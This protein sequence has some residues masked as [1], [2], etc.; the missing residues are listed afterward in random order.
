M[1]AI[2]EVLIMSVLPRALGS[3]RYETRNPMPLSKSSDPTFG[4]SD[5]IANR[6]VI[7]SLPYSAREP[8]LAIAIGIQMLVLRRKNP[9]ETWRPR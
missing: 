1:L 7:A 5:R 9:S 3:F 4:A 2:D 6:L 8:Q